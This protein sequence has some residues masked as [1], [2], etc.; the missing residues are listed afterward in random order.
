MRWLNPQRSEAEELDKVREELASTKRQLRNTRQRLKQIARDYLLLKMPQGAVCAEIGVDEGDFS[1]QIIGA[2]KPKKLHL[3]DP[4]QH[5][6]EYKGSCYGGLGPE[7]Q[8]EMDR[9]YLKVQ[10]RFVS[11]TKAGRAVLHRVTSEE[12]TSLFDDSHLDWLYLDANHLYEFAKLDLELFYPKI[13]PGGYI[14]GDDYGVKGWWEGGVTKAVN[15]FVKE[16]E[17]ELEVKATQF[18]IR[19]SISG[20][21]NEQRKA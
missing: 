10:E 2:T 19:K 12:A 16:K 3:I 8:S 4:W 7:G 15:E 5:L 21:F 18:I 6:D 9:K 14:C 13:K 20:T 1:E 11:E 17:L